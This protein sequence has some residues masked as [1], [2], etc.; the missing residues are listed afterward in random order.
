MSLKTNLI[1]IL[2][3][4]ITGGSIY[5]A[6]PKQ[7]TTNT[8][9]FVRQTAS[10]NSAKNMEKEVQPTSTSSSE[11]LIDYIVEGLS[12]DERNMIVSQVLTVPTSTTKEILILTN[13]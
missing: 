5:Y 9:V 4:I 2:G 11:M 8:S 12:S 7:I 6:Q 3:I 1:V 10:A 13:F